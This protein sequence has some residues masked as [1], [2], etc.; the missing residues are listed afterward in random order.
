MKRITAFVFSVLAVLTTVNG[1]MAQE[2]VVR[3]TIPF[4]FTV[5]NRSLPAGTY[6]IMPSL[7]NV[8]R[9]QNMHDM[10]NTA[11]VGTI[12]DSSEFH[13]KC[14]LVF[15]KYGSRYFLHEVRSP[16]AMNVDLFP[17]EEEKQVR[18]QSGMLNN[19][20]TILIAAR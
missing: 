3:A 8:I 4:D 7:G 17:S 9:I 13:D 11:S 5:K 6:E 20:N 16:A 10:H 14:V 12:R 1:A 2:G 18:Q 15:E 19:A